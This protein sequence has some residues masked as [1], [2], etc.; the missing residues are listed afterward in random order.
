MGSINTGRDD[1]SKKRSGM[2]ARTSKM[3]IDLGVL[4]DCSL[5]FLWNTLSDLASLFV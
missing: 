2:N 4:L 5:R 1:C 3:A